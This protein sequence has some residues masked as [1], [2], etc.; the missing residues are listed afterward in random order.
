MPKICCPDT[1]TINT[2][3]PQLLFCKNI[4][5]VPKRKEIMILKNVHGI[6]KGKENM[7]LK[8]EACRPDSS[9]FRID[10][11]ATKKVTKSQFKHCSK[12]L[13]WPLG[14]HSWSLFA[15]IHMKSLPKVN[16]VKLELIQ[17]LLKIIHLASI[18]SYMVIICPNSHDK[19]TKI[20]IWSS[21]SRFEHCSELL[22]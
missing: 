12:S 14:S 19:L 3:S 20:K 16:Q 22:I 1:H 21:W 9:V 8:Q 13:I 4:P 7:K 18:T 15:Q 10:F 5:W 2:V 17:T 6:F 11:L